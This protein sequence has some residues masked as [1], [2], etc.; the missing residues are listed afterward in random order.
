MVCNVEE[1]VGDKG[2]LARASGC[3]AIIVGHSE[4]GTRTR[5]KLPSGSRKTLSG[6]SRAM[7]GLVAGGGRTEK[8]ILKAGNS[9][10]K[11]KARRSVWPRIRG[12]GMNPVDHPHGGGNH[13]HV[14]KPTTKSRLASAGQKVIF[15][16]IFIFLFF[17]FFINKGFT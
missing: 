2:D 3:Y 1:R 6:D 9:H 14:G 8:P 13:Q 12:V 15:I 5:V 16:F 10:Y 7:I 4:D 17:F 11:H